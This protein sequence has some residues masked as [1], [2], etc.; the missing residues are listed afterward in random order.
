M[1]NPSFEVAWGGAW[2]RSQRKKCRQAAEVVV[3][4]AADFVQSQAIEVRSPKL[5]SFCKRRPNI[6]YAGACYDA[7]RIDIV[8]NR[9]T[10]TRGTVDDDIFLLTEAG[11]HESIHAL[12]YERFDDDYNHAE[13]AVQ[14][15]LAYAGSVMAFLP[16]GGIRSYRDL[17]ASIEPQDA[18]VMK[19]GDSELSNYL[20]LLVNSRY[21]QQEYNWWMR[22]QSRKLN[23]CESVGIVAVTTL[24]DHGALLVDLIDEPAAEILSDAADIL[25]TNE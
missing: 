6:P 25:K 18:R 8:V 24:L 5:F 4:F 19:S 3:G 12:R 21:S 14:E 17:L 9:H 7:Q 16:P 2:N 15:G 11:V 13:H 23:L 10:V 1:K 20:Q 22:P